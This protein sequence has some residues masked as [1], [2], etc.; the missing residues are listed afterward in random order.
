[1]SKR[2]RSKPSASPDKLTLKKASGMSD[3]LKTLIRISKYSRRMGE[4]MKALLQK[5]LLS[6]V[7]PTP[8]L[9]ITPPPAV[10]H[11]T[12][13]NHTTVTHPVP[14]VPAPRAGR[15]NRL[16]KSDLVSRHGTHA[17]TVS[18]DAGRFTSREAEPPS[19]ATTPPVNSAHTSGERSRHRASRESRASFVSDEMSLGATL[20]AYEAPLTL[21]PEEVPAFDKATGAPLSSV[22]PA[23]GTTGT[24]GTTNTSSH[25]LAL[26]F[27]P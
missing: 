25:S 11:S 27:A 8:L 10:P 4:R 7:A 2:K 12:G 15:I 16:S 9:I 14:H 5:K 13:P 23:T 6:V 18:A 3:I 1:M 17:S 21:H 22:T 26:S 20:H 24:T 19:H